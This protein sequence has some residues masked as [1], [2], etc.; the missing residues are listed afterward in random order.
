VVS[1]SE[2]PEPQPQSPNE[3]T[4]SLDELTAAFAEVIG[5][6]AGPDAGVRAQ[7]QEAAEPETDR[8]PTE[9]LADHPT[10]QG[11]QQ[12]PEPP[13]D[14][15]CPINPRSILE[16]MLFVGNR[17]SQPLRPARA[18]E[19]MRGVKPEEIAGLVEELNGRYAANGC[20]YHVVGDRSGYRLALRKAFHPLR[21][22]FYGRIREVRLSQAA[23]DVL[24]IVAYQ[25]P[26]TGEQIGRLRGKP[27]S[28]VVAQLVRR[29]LLRVER[30][31]PKR[32]TA[33]YFTTDRFL[34]LFG[35]ESLEDLP[36]SEELGR[37]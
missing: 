36:Q 11:P 27:S 8:V 9:Q 3:Q 4:I 1:M 25:Q 24:A 13:G 19:L 6:E 2:T 20:P 26:L 29:G 35:L 31:Q 14:D 34:K 22:R 10:E 16:A 23:I 37:Q 28:H 30:K 33:Q 5:A 17:D 32:R 12:G 21:N 18:A 15:P 7:P